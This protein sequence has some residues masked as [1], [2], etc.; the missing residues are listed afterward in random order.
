[1]FLEI[2]I[3]EV[4]VQ[5]E[6]NFNNTTM[7]FKKFKRNKYNNTKTEIDGILFDS[8]KE[9]NRYVFLKSLEAGGKIKDLELQKKY[10]LIPSV[11]EDY[12]VELKTKTVVKTRVKQKAI[13][14]KADF[15]YTVVKTEETIVEDVKSSPLA[16][17][18][19]KAFVL[20]KK[21]MLALLGIEVT[22]VYTA[23]YMSWA[24]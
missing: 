14:Y 15:V 18:Q 16:A 12:K 6:F 2:L 19:D 10:I 3:E 23:N 24:E 20:K 13:T 11:T 8:K 4:L 5:Q 1:M 7:F 21:M 22:E 9:A 17:A